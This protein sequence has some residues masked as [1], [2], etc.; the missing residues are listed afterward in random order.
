M[1]DG[2]DLAVVGAGIVGLGHAAAA[3][4]R[5]KRVVVVD[6][7]AAIVGAS[8]RNFGHVGVSMHA[9]RAGE[10]AKR[11]AE[12]W[13]RL[14]AEAGFW[15]RDAG[16]LVVAAAEDELAVLAESRGAGEDATLLDRDGVAA[17]APVA[18]AVGGMFRRGDLQVDPREAAAAIAVRLAAVGVEFRWRTA[19]LG[20][21]PGILHTSRGPIR[22][23]AIVVAANADVDELYPQ[24]A[25]EHGLQRCA[26]DMLL[27]E[28]VG[29]GMPLLT[30]TTLLRYTA[31]STM[32]SAAAVRARI[33][34]EHPELIA[35]DVN[36][37]YTER[38]DGS[39]LVGDTHRVAVT[40]GP[41]QD[42]DAGRALLAGA[43]RLFGRPLDVRQRWQGVYA[44]APDEF[45]VAAPADGIRVVAVTTGIG[46]TCGLGLAETV[47]DELI[48]AA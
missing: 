9:G 8:V 39:L 10:L 11:S 29:L 34:R 21:E 17:L 14:A 44:K 26:L 37:M 6:R 33:E 24:L 19:A 7:S 4:R 45:L 48:G 13:R 3:A 41:F 28:G 5:G 42:E 46:M 15:L 38:P 16:S 47:I 1:N 27:T 36:Q 18:H 2:Y 22:A 40:P 25:E 30:G 23:A 12:L 31:F 43:A 20:A 32:P 35:Y